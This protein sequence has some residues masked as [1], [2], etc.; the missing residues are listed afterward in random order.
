MTAT[1]DLFPMIAAHRRRTAD[2]IQGLSEADA[3]TPSLCSDWTVHQV[4]AHLTMP[5]S[6]SLP[7]MVVGM[8]RHR[9][10]F[11]SFN[12][13]WAVRT[14]G[15]RSPAELAAYLR[16]H[17][18]H[19]FTPPGLGPGA[20]LTDVLVH[21]LDISVPLGRDNP[22]EPA[23][24][25]ASLAFVCDP[26]ASRGFVPSGRLAG[27]RLIC[28]DSAFELGEGHEVRG[29]GAALLLALTGRRRGLDDLSG[30]GVDVLRS[31]F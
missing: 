15:A 23:H 25:D 11:D 6:L 4:A 12:R 27:L 29:P 9:G 14:A 18:E 22:L 2:L 13:A 8:V 30:D 26:G 5:F 16:S 31:R 7:G 21:S 24:V 1:D 10:R 19:R 17:A 3:R 20:P 28:T